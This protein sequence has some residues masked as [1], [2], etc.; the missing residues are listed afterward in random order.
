MFNALLDVLKRTNRRTIDEKDIS[1][2]EKILSEISRINNIDLGIRYPSSYDDYKNIIAHYA[3]M[4]ENNILNVT[5]TLYPWI[6]MEELEEFD[7]LK[8]KVLKYVLYKKRSEAEIRR[9]FSESSEKMLNKVIDD[10]K[11]SGYI[12]DSMYIARTV[13][14]FQRLKNLSIKELEYK[15]LSKGLDK[16]DIED[17]VSKNKEELLE[18]EVASAK[19]IFAKKEAIMEKEDIILYLNKK[20]YLNE[21]I[22][23]AQEE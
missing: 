3:Y 22:K 19:N 9:K 2:F 10:L 21:S 17:Y 1:D 20:G 8:T 6:N 13:N 7:K 18:Y 15:L 11:E 4:D 16:N 14:E 12:D 5:Y 23:L